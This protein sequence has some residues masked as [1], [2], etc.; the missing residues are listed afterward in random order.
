MIKPLL[1]NYLSRKMT[2]AFI[3]NVDFIRKE[4]NSYSKS[5]KDLKILDVGCG[6][7]EVTNKILRDLKPSCFQIYGLDVL[8]SVRYAKIKYYKQDLEHKKFPFSNEKFDIVYSNQVLE[9]LLDK[10]NFIMECFRVLKEGGLFIL[11]TEN[12]ASFDNIISLFLS[13]EPLSQNSSVKK[14]VN[15]FLSPHFGNNPLGGIPEMHKNVCSYFSLK[16]LVACNTDSQMEIKSFG[17]IFKV[18]EIIFPF[19][20]RLLTVYGLKK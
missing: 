15:S 6:D 3:D 8:K 19:Y 5:R 9:H 14:Q 10:D 4:I 18:F 1:N 12:I 16:R 11:S 20:N 13:Q 2:R 17:N 7:G